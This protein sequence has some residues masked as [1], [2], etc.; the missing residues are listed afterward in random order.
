M[1]SRWLHPPKLHTPVQGE[2]R[3]V[4]WL[5]LFYDL[6]YVATFIQLGNA[7]SHHASVGGVLV[8]AGLFVPIWYTWTGFTFYSNRFVVDDFGHRVMVFA[9]MFAIGA[10][11][12]SVPAVF[13]GAPQRFGL[14]YSAARAVLVLLY[15]RSWRQVRAAR[16]MTGRFVVAFSV[17][18]VLWLAGALLPAPWT[19]LLWVVAMTVDLSAALSPHARA[20][21]AQHPPDVVHFSERYGLLTL[22]VLGESFVKVLSEVATRGPTSATA[23]LA[24]LALVVTC[25]LWW[26]YFDDVAGSRLKRT[27]LAAYVWIYA[28]LP[29]TMAIIAVGVAVKKAVFFS[30]WAVETAAHRW[31]LCGSLGLALLAVG[32]IDS[33]TE[34]RQADLSDAARVRMRVFSAFLVL[35]LA[36]V[37]GFMPSWVFVAMVAGACALQVLFDL[38]MAPMAAPPE[39]AD[40][41]PRPEPVAQTAPAGAR[42]WDVSDAV[43]RGAPNELRRDLYFHL[44]EGSWTRVLATLAVVYFL[45][46]LVFAALYLVDQGGVTEL[47][48]GGFLEAFSFSIQTI[49]TI[50]YG[51]MSPSS[52][53]ADILVAVESAVG[54]LF[55]ALATGI[56]FAKASRPGSGALFSDRVVV[57]RYHGQRTLMLRVGNARGNDVVEANMR[58][59][60]LVDEE[61]PEGIKTRKLYDLRLLRQMT[62][63]F[64]LTWTVFHT[65]DETSPLHGIEAGNVHDR[66]V[67]LIC[68]MTGYDATYAQT[69]HARRIYYPENIYFDH[70]LVDVISALPDGRL[71]VDY[72][73]FHDVEPVS[74]PA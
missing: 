5:E 1:E 24:S 23:G 20:L 47:S 31:L 70:R 32:L 22:I 52:P 71:M 16:E 27:R 61:S 73:R 13:D 49:A 17:G 30:P 3:H 28:H 54:I 58:V 55:V 38:S 36:P 37:G 53:Y 18:A 6:V 33:V 48:G 39:P 69:T 59:A 45:V 10:M 68:T 60:V 42:R 4:G 40:P 66:L 35:V 56:V 29:M 62:P 19:L 7:L 25:S 9:Q 51:V 72:E 74:D 12:V 21:A 67:A 15:A 64:A 11:A 26:I 63:L 65:V 8:F 34:R 2:E 57:T 46:N 44:M 41:R 43:R 50:G 14:A